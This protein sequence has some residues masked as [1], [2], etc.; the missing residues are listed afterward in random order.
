MAKIGADDLLVHITGAVTV[1]GLPSAGERIRKGQVIARLTNDGRHID[2]ASP[3]TGVV[4]GINQALSGNA[5]VIAGDPYDG[6]WMCRIKPEK[7][8]EETGA[9]YMAEDAR[10]WFRNEVLRFREFILDVANAG[11][12]DQTVA[13][14]QEGGE[15]TD[16]ILAG[17]PGEIWEKF[18]SG[19]LA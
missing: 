15:L 6:G 13:V 19:F 5:E 11:S 18:Q 2:L 4:A 3:V 12:Q 7:W 14:L 16:H 1:E 17:M 10:T 9:C 8:H